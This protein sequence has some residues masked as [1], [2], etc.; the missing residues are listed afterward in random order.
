MPLPTP[1]NTVQTIV[2]QIP[3]TAKEWVGGLVILFF[4]L[5]AV[6]FFCTLCFT[7]CRFF[8]FGVGL[9]RPIN[10]ETPPVRAKNK[11]P[12]TLQFQNSNLNRK[13]RMR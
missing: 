10:C 4:S 2:M 7:G 5:G 6:V 12:I 3:Y 11:I 8:V 13:L 1:D 9:N